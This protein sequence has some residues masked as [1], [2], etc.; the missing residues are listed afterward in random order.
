VHGLQFREPLAVRLLGLALLFLDVAERR[1]NPDDFEPY[2]VEA[3]GKA[4]ATTGEN[5]V[6]RPD[7]EPPAAKMA[8][9]VATCPKFRQTWN[10]DRP[11]LTDQSQS[12]FDL[13]LA[14]IAARLGWTD[15][16]TADLLI[17]ARRHTGE[18]P[19]KA[20]RPD[21]VRRTIGRGRAAADELPREDMD[22]DLSGI[23]GTPEAGETVSE[24]IEDP[25]PIPDDLLRIPGFVAEVI[26]Y[27]LETAPY[28]E[29]VLAFSGALELQA[30]LA[31]RKVRDAGDNRT[32]LYLL[33]LANSGTGK[34][35]P[36]KVN[37]QVLLHAGMTGCLGDHFASGEGIEDRMFVQPAM[38]FQT[39]EIDGL[40]TAINK[41]RDVRF[42]GIMNVLL[43]MYT[44]ANALYPMRVKAGKESGG[45]IN[46]PCL[47]L[48]GTAI[49]H[50]CYQAMSAKMLDNGFFARL[51]ILEA[52]PRARGQD[53]RVQDLPD[54]ILAVAQEWERFRPGT[55]NLGEFN[56]KPVI[57]EHTDAAARVLRDV[58]EHADEEYARAEQADDRVGMAIWARANE[59]ARKLALIHA[60][61]ENPTAPIISDAAARWAWRFVEHQTRRMLFMAA[62]HVS[63]NEFH[64]KCNELVR[65]L[66]EWRKRKGNR[67]MPFWQVNRKL[68]WS[69]REHDD[70]RT[71]LVNMKRVDYDEKRTGGPPKRLYR[72]RVGAELVAR[73]GSDEAGN[74]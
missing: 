29:P 74:R 10:H 45:H 49:P 1:Y 64:A 59:K 67:W 58:R 27:T 50:H 14:S 4:P 46:Q 69:E 20:L 66:R 48:F 7:A 12:G 15:Q 32:N 19:E 33:A 9:A 73:N 55:G 13:A 30:F 36:R 43:K 31:G 40:L 16:E 42:E 23:V 70:V 41:G 63:Q 24:D 39:D 2:L 44:T 21:Y 51:L 8:E 28:P 54:R 37:Q 65:V 61:S 26:D 72:L 22:V 6:L 60:C 68:P 56:P 5:L 35:H 17:A 52:G 71:A 47:C 3:A 11:D 57:V 62:E 34:D 25:G 38:L 18:K 53:Y